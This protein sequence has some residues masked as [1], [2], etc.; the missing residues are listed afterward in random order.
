MEKI[1]SVLLIAGLILAAGGV[2]ENIMVA[3]LGL[4]LV[5]IACLLAN[6]SENGEHR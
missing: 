6:V 4:V 1:T 3:G 5:G 2:E